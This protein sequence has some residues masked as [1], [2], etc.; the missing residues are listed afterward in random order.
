MALVLTAR[1][2]WFWLFFSGASRGS[3]P[4]R[5]WHEFC[6][7]C[8]QP[9]SGAEEPSLD[10][11]IPALFDRRQQLVTTEYVLVEL[12]DALTSPPVRAAAASAVAVFR[13]R[14]VLRIV[15]ASTALLDEG[16][17]WFSTHADKRWSLTDCISFVVMRREGIIDALTNDHH[18]EQAGFRALLRTDPP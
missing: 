13:R 7:S 17:G 16:I 3:G 12:L 4:G 15:P 18:F 1:S 2:P 8:G 14:R 11:R 5:L 10:R 6:V 9:H